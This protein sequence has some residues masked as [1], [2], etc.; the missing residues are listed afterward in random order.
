MRKLNDTD[1]PTLLS[2]SQGIEVTLKIWEEFEKA[3]K[4]IRER[5]RGVEDRDREEGWGFGDLVR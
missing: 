2:T 1:I 5:E 4:N 3:R